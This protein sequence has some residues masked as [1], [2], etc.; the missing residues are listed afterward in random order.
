[1]RAPNRLAA[2]LPLALAALSAAADEGEALS[3]VARIGAT[4]GSVSVK[5]NGTEE[6]SFAGP[7]RR[8]GTGDQVWTDG[9]SVTE[10]LVA[11]AAGAV[12]LRSPGRYRVEVGDDEVTVR[13]REGTAAVTAGGAEFPVEEGQ[14]GPSS[15]V[16]LRSTTSWARSGPTSGT[17]L[18]RT[19]ARKPQHAPRW[20]AL[21]P[22]SQA[23]S[24]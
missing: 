4:Y 18:L 7:D 1:M 14:G 21:L 11:I 16:N 19:P 15:P 8:L 3:R 22:P 17:R 6:W 23:G 2:I 12:S 10:L 13:V 20:P 5:A 9:A 24:S